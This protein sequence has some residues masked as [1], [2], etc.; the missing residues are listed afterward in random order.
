MTGICPPLGKRELK[1]LQIK[2]SPR[3]VQEALSVWKEAHELIAV[4]KGSMVLPLQDFFDRF[5]PYAAQSRAIS[6]L[7]K[8]VQQVCLMVVTIGGD[9][10]SRSRKHFAEKTV[11]RGYVL[12]RM[13]SYLAETEMRKLDSEITRGFRHLKRSTTKRYSPGYRDFSIE[14][15]KVFVGLFDRAIP[16]LELLPGFL[17]KPEKTITALKGVRPTETQGGC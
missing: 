3:A 2:E 14:A 1:Y 6:S 16:C 10:E 5:H 13:G 9:L 12:D 15:Q 8:G 4:Q 17:L 11:F 7:M